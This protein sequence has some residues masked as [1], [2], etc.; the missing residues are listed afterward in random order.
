MYNCHDDCGR[1]NTFVV[2]DEH[3]PIDKVL[4]IICH[5]NISCVHIQT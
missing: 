3:L 5:A 2:R 4:N 1:E